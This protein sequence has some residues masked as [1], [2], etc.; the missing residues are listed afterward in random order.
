VTPIGKNIEHI[1]DA[2]W[3]IS[4]IHRAADGRSWEGKAECLVACSLDDGAERF[5]KVRNATDPPHLL[6]LLRRAVDKRM[7]IKRRKKRK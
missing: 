7:G 3:W 6:T 2:G 5:V 4:E 1:A